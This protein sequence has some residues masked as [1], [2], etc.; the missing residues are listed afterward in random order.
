[1]KRIT[2]NTYSRMFFFAALYNLSFAIPGLLFPEFSISL[3]FGPRV[4]QSIFINFYASSFYYMFWG[5][6]LIFGIGYY[7]VSRDITKNRG[8]VWMGIIGKTPVFIYFCY[9]YFSGHS[10]LLSLLGGTGD[11]MFTILFLL[12]LWQTRSDDN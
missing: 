1:M 7:F 5:S 11:L 4:I 12:F 8:I 10:L 9:S 6:V 2:D 3:A